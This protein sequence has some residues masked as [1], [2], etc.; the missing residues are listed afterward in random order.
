MYSPVVT[1]FD[2]AEH[3]DTITD[4]TRTHSRA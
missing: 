4:A 1:Y 3:T 2:G